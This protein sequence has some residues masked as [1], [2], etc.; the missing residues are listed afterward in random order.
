MFQAVSDPPA[1]QPRS[2]DVLV[3]FEAVNVLGAEHD[4]QAVNPR[5]LTGPPVA[6]S[7]PAEAAA[8]ITPA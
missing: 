8:I 3:M 5:E 6:G 4:G 7:L 1:T 2:A